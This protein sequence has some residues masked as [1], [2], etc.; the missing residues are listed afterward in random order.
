MTLRL[1]PR[2]AETKNPNNLANNKFGRDQQPIKRRNTKRGIR[3]ESRTRQ[4]KQSRSIKRNISRNLFRHPNSARHHRLKA[5]GAQVPTC[6]RTLFKAAHSTFNLNTCTLNVT[7]L[8]S[9]G[10]RQYLDQVLRQKKL[11]VLGLQETKTRHNGQE[12]RKTYTIYFR[13]QDRLEEQILKAR[14]S[15]KWAAGVAIA[16]SNKLT[17][18]IHKIHPINDRLMI[19]D[20]NLPVRLIFI[21]TYAPTAEAEDYI[22]TGFY[23]MLSHHTFQYI[24][25]ESYIL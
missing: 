2:S 14:V 19:V 1:Q 9:L 17:N 24:K 22:K 20:F 11:D 12:K 8:A 5:L 6:R 3:S 10:Q 15:T 18:F 7:T 16:I 23:N 13:G 21:V 4:R 25:K